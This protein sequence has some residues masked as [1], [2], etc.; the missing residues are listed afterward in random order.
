MDSTLLTSALTSIGVSLLT[1]FGVQS[2]F[3]K[4]IEHRFERQLERYRADLEVKVHA[5][6]GIADRRLKGYPR[7][8]E[9]CYRTRNMAR[10]ATQTSGWGAK[11][12]LVARVS[13]LEDLLYRFRIDLEADRHFVGVHKYKNLMREFCRMLPENAG[14]PAVDALAGQ[15]SELLARTYAAIE[16]CHREVVN[17]LT[18]DVAD[19]ADATGA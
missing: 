9:L 8:V 16:T 10:D 5:R 6:Q 3:T 12:D 11:S 17:Q 1:A 2:Y 19:D 15:D 13:E 18:L 7:L 14:S 4:R